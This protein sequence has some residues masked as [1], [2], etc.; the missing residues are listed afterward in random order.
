MVPKNRYRKYIQVLTALRRKQT[1]VALWESHVPRFLTK[2]WMLWLQLTIIATTTLY[3]RL[4]PANQWTVKRFTVAYAKKTQIQI[5]VTIIMAKVEWM[6]LKSIKDKANNLK[7]YSLNVRVRIHTYMYVC[8]IVYYLKK[9]L[10]LFQYYIFVVLLFYDFPVLSRLLSKFQRNFV[11]FATI[12]F[13]KIPI[14]NHLKCEST[15]VR[16]YICICI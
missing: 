13:L 4:M 5:S 1:F 16:T 10:P 14:Q 7:T 8:D 12:S 2:P 6:A 15:H 3:S 11:L 9:G